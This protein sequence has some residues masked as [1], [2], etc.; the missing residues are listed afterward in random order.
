MDFRFAKAYA[1]MKALQLPDVTSD[2]QQ[3]VDTASI[4]APDTGEL[5]TADHIVPLLHGMR[6]PF[7]R[8]TFE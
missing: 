4:P 6:D 7:F 1:A 8:R 3:K 5:L 2:K